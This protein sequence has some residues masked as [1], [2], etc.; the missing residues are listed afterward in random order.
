MPTLPPSPQKI[1]G[2]YTA[3]PSASVCSKEAEMISSYGDHTLTFFAL[4]PENRRFLAP[5][6]AGL[7]HYRLTRKVAVVPGSPIC[8][9]EARVQVTRSFLDFCS[10]MHWRVAFYQASAEYFAICHA[11]N[12][13]VFKMGEEAIIHPQTFTLQGAVLANVRTSCRRAAR[14]GVHIH[15]YE[16][17]PPAEV[18]QQLASISNAWLQCKGGKLAAETGFSTGTLH[19]LVQ[20]AELA[21]MIAN[22]AAPSNAPLQVVPRFV[23]GVAT[24]HTGQVC[25]FVTFTPI[26]GFLTAHMTAANERVGKPGWGW[27]LDLMRRIPETPPGVMELLLVQAIGRFR[28]CGAQVVSLGLAAMADTRQEMSPGE[29]R[30][31]RFLPDRLGLLESRQTLFRFKQKFHPC[32]ESRYLVAN[33]TVALPGIALALLRLRNYPAG[34]WTRLLSRAMPL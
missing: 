8:A 11:L 18:M 4:T 34:R 5:H 19:D 32:W 17:I 30:L 10:R 31:A 20:S 28:S 22:R 15:W 25:A 29:R 24:T 16:G 14:E 9:P 23:T 7:V 26:Y 1:A 13:R 3:E 6:G 12:L 2:M 27:A 33:T 21:D